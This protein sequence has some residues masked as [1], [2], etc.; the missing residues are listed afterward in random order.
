MQYVV[1]M[2]VY[3]LIDF[4]QQVFPHLLKNFAQIRNL[5]HRH[6]YVKNERE[7]NVVLGKSQ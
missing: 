4:K 7:S 2:F 5:R 6:I 1:K 3:I